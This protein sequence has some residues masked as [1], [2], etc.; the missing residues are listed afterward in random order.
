MYNLFEKRVCTKR[1]NAM[2]KKNN[3]YLVTAELLLLLSLVFVFTGLSK[4]FYLSPIF[5]S[6]I[7]LGV[8]FFINTD[9]EKEA[10]FLDAIIAKESSFEISVDEKKPFFKKIQKA[11]SLAHKGM[12]GLLD[13]VFFML[14]RGILIRE[15]TSYA[16]EQCEGIKKSVDICCR[17]Q[18]NISAA[19]EEISAAVSETAQVTNNDTVKCVE[20]TSFANDIIKQVEEG[21]KKAEIVAHS[22]T[23]L[24]T[25]SKNLEKQMQALQKNS[26]SIGNIIEGIKTI[27]GQTNLLALNAAIEAARAGEHGK[28]FA[29]VAEEVKKLAEKTGQMTKLVENEIK[30]IQEISRLNMQAS[31]ETITSLKE[32][33]DEFSELNTTLNVV[34]EQIQKMESIIE[35]VTDN[36]QGSAARTEQMN[37]AVMNVAANIEAFTGQLG[38]IE[39]VVGEFLEVQVDIQ[40]SSAPLI[41][42]AS[43]LKSIEKV[44]FID[45]RLQDHH[46]WVNTLKDAIEKRNPDVNLQLNH[47]L[48]KF[49]KWYFNY[50][51]TARERDVFERINRPHKGIHDSGHKIIEELKKRNYQAAERIFQNETLKYME[52]V[53]ALF[54]ELKRIFA[55][56]QD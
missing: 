23:N 36:F 47:T 40:T 19:V 38:N 10:P 55:E 8:S 1:G 49:G 34:T 46:N 53:Q 52:E 35:V 2:T 51:P 41:E 11:F 12:V 31:S 17:Q 6:I 26:E 30:T 18:E 15:K 37:A 3:G 42:F 50:E 20:L 45:L 22:F 54:A 48:C 44:Y 43:N 4:V 5:L 27:A 7:V 28:G 21:K 33:E 9:D 24:Q 13:K 25:S 29:V 32:S 56:E 16:I 39:S 14:E